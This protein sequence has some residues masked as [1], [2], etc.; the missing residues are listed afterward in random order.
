MDR[1]NPRSSVVSTQNSQGGQR[2]IDS[3]GGQNFQNS[4]LA[5]VSVPL[6]TTTIGNDIGS[7]KN[8]FHEYIIRRLYRF[9]K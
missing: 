2:A 8:I 5:G 3:Q 7:G 6:N 4:T 9:L 1:E